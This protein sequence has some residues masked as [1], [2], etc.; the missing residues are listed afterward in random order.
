[1]NHARIES[2]DHEGNKIEEMESKVKD[3]EIL[4]PVEPECL[5]AV[6]HDDLLDLITHIRIIW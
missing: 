5:V 4:G 6:D 2:F 1:M 3:P